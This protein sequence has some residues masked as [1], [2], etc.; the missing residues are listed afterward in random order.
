MANRGSTFDLKLRVNDKEVPNTLTKLNQEFYKLRYSVNSLEE[1]TEKWIKKNQQLAVVEQKRKEA[2]ENQKLYRKELLKTI[3]AEDENSKKISEFGDNFSKAFQGIR[4]GDLVAAREGLNGIKQGIVGATKAGLAFIATPIGLAIAA[5]AGIAFATKKWF[6]YNTAAVEALRVTKQITGLSEQAADQ[7]RISGEILTE[8]FGGDFKTNMETARNLVTQFGISYD[9]AFAIIEDKLVRGQRNNDEFFDS[10]REYPT[11]FAQA[12]FSANEFADV[13]AAGYDLGIYNDKLPDALKE[14]DLSLREQTKATREALVNAFGA[15]FTDSI[16]ERV[17]R[18]E[19]STKDA[20]KAISAEA[21]KNNINIQQNAQLTADL[22]RGAGEDAGGALKVFE[23]LNVALNDQKR[24]LTESEEIL[25]DQI[26][27]TEELKEVSSALFFT[28][29]K[30]FGLLIDKGKLL[31]TKILVGILRAGVDVINWFV[32][33][34][35]ESRVFSGIISTIGKLATVQFEV[36]GTLIRAAGK[37]FGGLG[38]IITGVFTLD[39]DKIQSGFTKLKDTVIFAFDDIKKKGKAAAADIADAFSG[40]KK[41]ERVTLDSYVTDETVNNGPKEGDTKTEGGVTYIFKNG[42][43]VPIATGGGGGEDD[44]SEKEAKK[45]ADKEKAIREKVREQLKE[46]EK[47]REIQDTLEKFEKDKRKEE[48]EILELENKFAKLIEEA[49]SEKE[50]IADLEEQKLALIQNIRDK[51]A[52]ERAEKKEE[53]LKKLTE[54]EKQWA[55]ASIDAQNMLEQA[56]ANAYTQGIGFLKSFLNEKTGLYKALFLFEKAAA[57][58]EILVNTSKSL[59]A[60]QASTAAGVAEATAFSPLTLGQPWAA[61][62]IATGST[63]ALATKINA[64][65]Q[66]ASIAGAT[67]QG[68]FDGG[69]TGGMYAGFNDQNGRKVAGLVHQNEYVIP[70]IIR[71]DPEMPMIENYI[72][73]KRRKKL[74]IY[75]DG[76]PVDSEPSI[77]PNTSSGSFKNSDPALIEAMW[78]FIEAISNPLQAEVYFGFEA[79]E[80]RAEVQKKMEKIKKRSKINS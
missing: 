10:L 11:F 12:K 44:D 30:G 19:L 33:L 3:D 16:L 64:G 56:K 78:A 32:D 68:F 24:P 76:G 61:G 60:I 62:I 20:L 2:I 79:E 17:R 15:P 43:W 66:L 74:G 80:K 34:N 13:I 37:W 47:E 54:K 27:A 48:R 39:Q 26:T 36:I 7:A 25:Q 4:N 59:A 65:I 38:D 46:W 29:D 6:D 9:E 28:G 1:G 70:E 5:L 63:Q 52:E 49:G 8:T 42:K 73:S 35:N 14:A 57:A 67:I 31:G 55:Q 40:K 69:P 53:E 21:D 23:A 77:I 71:R 58:N 18:G 75:Q 72:E 45:R 51:Y 22:F 41:M 50:L